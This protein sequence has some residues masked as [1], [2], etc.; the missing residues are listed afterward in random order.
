LPNPPA[1]HAATDF[2]LPSFVTGLWDGEGCF[3][4]RGNIRPGR[5]S[6]VSAGAS[7]GL[8]ADD[9]EL[10]RLVAR[11][12]GVGRLTY[13]HNHYPAIT[14]RAC[15]QVIWVCTR[16]R[17]LLSAVVPHFD[18][19]P[20]RGKKLDEYLLWRQIVHAIAAWRPGRPRSAANVEQIEGLVAAVRALRQYRHDPALPAQL[21]SARVI[22]FSA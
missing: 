10:V 11:Y 6:N 3:Q 5:V 18:R 16:S 20:P 17:D 8:R 12:F 14:T 1:G 2:H 21:Q 19:Y 4:V 13:K 15:P 7:L 22:P 9:V